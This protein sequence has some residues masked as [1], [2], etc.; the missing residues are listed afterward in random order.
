M[1]K[2]YRIAALKAMALLAKS[3]NDEYAVDYWLTYCRRT[4]IKI[5]PLP[6]KRAF[7]LL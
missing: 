5:S 7:V 1:N 2:N 6:Q 3:S 4:G